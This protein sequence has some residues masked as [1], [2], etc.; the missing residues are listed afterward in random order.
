[1]QIKLDSM[2]C[3]SIQARRREE[4]NQEYLLVF[5]NSG[6][7]FKIRE[8]SRAHSGIVTMGH[9]D[10]KLGL[11]VVL[12][13]EGPTLSFVY[14]S[15]RTTK[16]LRQLRIQIE[17]N[18]A[19]YHH[20]FRVSSDKSILLFYHESRTDIQVRGYISL[21]LRGTLDLI[22]ICKKFDLL[23]CLDEIKVSLEFDFITHLGKIV[24]MLRNKL[25][26]VRKDN[27]DQSEVLFDFA[28]LTTKE[29]LMGLRYS[30]E[31]RVLFVMGMASFFL[32]GFDDEGLSSSKIIECHQFGRAVRLLGWDP[33]DEF[34][35]FA[36]STTCNKE[37]Y[38]LID[39]CAT[40]P[41]IVSFMKWKPFLGT[42]YDSEIQRLFYIEVG[43]DQRKEIRIVNFKDFRE[44]YDMDNQQIESDLEFDT[45]HFVSLHPDHEMFPYYFMKSAKGLLYFRPLRGID[46]KHVKE[47]ALRL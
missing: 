31:Q 33:K 11:G 23:K 18:Y 17:N 7:S 42:Y 28:E 6:K 10:V 2:D 45:E 41:K 3:F 37:N 40:D 15:M 24:L 25:I 43:F 29:R 12:S 36:Q 5:V 44:K 38:Q 30:S 16:P 14:Y 35:L 1:M 26:L 19:N 34:I 21:K 46:E 4:L 22:A 8:D 32:F 39:Y 20:I 47:A 9:H 27:V 13:R